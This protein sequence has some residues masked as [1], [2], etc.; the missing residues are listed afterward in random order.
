MFARVVRYRMKP[1]AVERA[2]A[3]LDAMKPQIMTLPGLIH[4]TNMMNEDGSGVVVSVVESQETSDANQD[5]VQALWANFADDLVEP[6]VAE[7]Y[8]VLMN[9]SN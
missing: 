9:E 3:K 7:G 5:R 4:F 8:D 1:E 6:P 2:T